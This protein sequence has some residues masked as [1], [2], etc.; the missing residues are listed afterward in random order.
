MVRQIPRHLR[1]EVKHNNS[2]NVPIFPQCVHFLLENFKAPSLSYSNYRKIA[3]HLS[4]LCSVLNK[5]IYMYI[6]IPAYVCSHTNMLLN[7]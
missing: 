3:Y 5:Q 4:V 6:H 2:L 1:H 7:I